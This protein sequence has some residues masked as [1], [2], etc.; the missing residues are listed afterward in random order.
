M[1][2]AMLTTVDNPY[3][4]FIQFD[5]WFAFD[6]QKGYNTC[7]YLDRLVIT[8]DEFSDE[9]N[10]KIIEDAIDEIVALNPLGIFRKVYREQLEAA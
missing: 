7:G 10:D 3:N 4:P 8:S 1:S 2:D 9:D 6:I 5:E